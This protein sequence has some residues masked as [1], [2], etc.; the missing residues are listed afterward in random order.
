MNIEKTNKIGLII[1]SEVYSKITPNKKHSDSKINVLV[2]NKTKVF[3]LTKRL[4]D[5][6]DYVDVSNIREGWFDSSFMNQSLSWYIMQ[7]SDLEVMYSFH[8]VSD[9][10]FFILCYEGYKYGN[11]NTFGST[12]NIKDNEFKF[13]LYR[14]EK[15][16]TADNDRKKDL[17]VKGL[18]SLAYI[19]FGDVKTDLIKPQKNI[20]LGYTKIWNRSDTDVY[21]VD[22]LWKRR[23]TTSGF[24]VSGH[25]RLQACGKG[26]SKRK[27]IWIESFE[28]DGYNRLAT[29]ELK[30]I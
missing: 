12:Y 19:V 28:K 2:S 6:C 24:S 23:V 25:F 8:L 27:L 30:N 10:E 11:L 14:G 13:N 9:H 3:R 1:S 5:H 21:F 4:M 26:F 7:S 18:K 17:L 15:N 29:K 16:I 22:S 20:K